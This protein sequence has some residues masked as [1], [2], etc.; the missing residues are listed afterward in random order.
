[1]ENTKQAIVIFASDDHIFKITYPDIVVFLFLNSLAEI[2][3]DVEYRIPFTV[4]NSTI[5]VNMWVHFYTVKVWENQ[6]QMVGQLHCQ[7]VTS[8]LHCIRYLYN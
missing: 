3:K 2:Q 8:A 6:K 5:N 7:S 1:M 4:N